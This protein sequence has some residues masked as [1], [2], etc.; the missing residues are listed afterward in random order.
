MSFTQFP[1]LPT[2]LR[3]MV[4]KHA[5]PG[6]RIIKLFNLV[7]DSEDGQIQI[8]QQA[9]EVEVKALYM[10][11]K[12]SNEVVLENYT[13]YSLFRSQPRVF[14][15]NNLDTLYFADY[16]AVCKFIEDSANGIQPQSSLFRSLQHL[17][18]LSPVWKESPIIGFSASRKERQFTYFY[19]LITQF[20]NLK[21]LTFI[22]GVPLDEEELG[23]MFVILYAAGEYWL[24]G[25]Y[26]KALFGP[27]EI[28]TAAEP[29]YLPR[30]FGG[31][32]NE[33]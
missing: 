6:P 17:A 14:I 24:P 1:R 7:S 22:L 29:E 4:W 26:T 18:V 3:L 10:T 21:Y 23:V 20:T 15:S 12:E 25:K 30:V 16:D 27:F 2:E 8:S 31:Y 13:L 28:N 33:F 32:D 19:K 9:D 5:L 11:C